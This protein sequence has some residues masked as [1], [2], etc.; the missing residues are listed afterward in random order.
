MNPRLS[1]LEGAVRG[2]SP[3]RL[4]ILL[5]GQAI[6]DLRCALAAHVRGEIEGRTRAINHAL[7]VIAHLQGTLDRKQGGTVAANLDRFYNQLRSGLMEAQCRQSGA[8]L[9]QEITN[10]MLLRDAWNTVEHF[11]FERSTVEH[12]DV[13]RESGTGQRP[14]DA[15]NSRGEWK[16]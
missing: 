9:E 16:A 11:A 8:A 10:L 1:Y 13:L 6:E 15:G 7:V 14:V 2:A 5:Y 12:A 3:V 4:V